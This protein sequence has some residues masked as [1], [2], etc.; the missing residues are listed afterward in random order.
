MSR[1]LADIERDIR[2]LNEQDRARL[3]RALIA[4]LDGPADTDAD[5]AW[6]EESEKR[7]AEIDSG[8]VEAVPAESVIQKARSL[9]RK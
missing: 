7:L 6:L 1:D 5:Q 8:A 2:A 4:D 9:L 3:L